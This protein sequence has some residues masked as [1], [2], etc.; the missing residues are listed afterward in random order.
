MTY[1]V[2]KTYDWTSSPIGS[3]IRKNAPW[4][5]VQSYELISNQIYQTI[6]NYMNIGTEAIENDAA[7]FYDN[8]YSKSTTKEDDFRFPFFGDNIRSFGNAFGDTFQDGVGG[9]GG[10]ASSLFDTAKS[11]VGG[12]GQLAGIV[13]TSDLMKAFKQFN[14][15]DHAKAA[16]TFR[17]G[18]T[19]GGDPGT[20]IESPMFYQFEKSDA[21]LEVSFVLANTI[22]ENSIGDNHKLV[23]L[24]TTINRPLRK[25]S[26]AVNPPRIYR[27]RVPGY[28]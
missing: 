4:V 6:L 27:V 19:S 8:M 12:V 3:E 26:I 17:N 22:N 28:R 23:Q 2:V 21:P 10:I 15:G 25:N 11:F 5:W 18:L 16:E 20:Y 13:G 1:D 7:K 14:S 24:L 9:G